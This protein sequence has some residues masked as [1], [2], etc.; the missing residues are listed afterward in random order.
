MEMDILRNKGRLTRL[1]ILL[2]LVTERPADQRS[3]AEPI[4]ITPQ[5]V[6]E[7]VHRMAGEGLVKVTPQGP[8][9]T[10]EGW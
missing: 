5:A 9:A 1:L 6:S 7:Y 2:E 3:V 4:G 10:M 8:R